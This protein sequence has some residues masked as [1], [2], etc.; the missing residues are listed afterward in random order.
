MVKH[1]LNSCI[2]PNIAYKNNLIYD[3]TAHIAHAQSRIVPDW[4]NREAYKNKRGCRMG[5]VRHLYGMYLSR[6]TTHIQ[7]RGND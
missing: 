2:L 4:E 3:I 1:H 6:W 5:L 7:T